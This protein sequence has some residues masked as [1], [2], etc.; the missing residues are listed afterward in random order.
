MPSMTEVVPVTTATLVTVTLRCSLSEFVT[1]LELTAKITTLV[2]APMVR[3]TAE[4][5]VVI[6]EV[7]AVVVVTA[8]VVA[9]AYSNLFVVLATVAITAI[10]EKVALVMTIIKLPAVHRGGN[11]NC[12]WL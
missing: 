5:Q 4:E 6:A 8:A 3:V 10:T 1:A 9:V 12:S 2:D 11:S 7:V